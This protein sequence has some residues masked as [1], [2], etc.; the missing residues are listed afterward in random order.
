MTSAD[1]LLHPVRLRIIQA[2]LGDRALTTAELRSELPDVPP[3]S[4]YRHIARLAEA[5]VLSVASE[6]RVRG[7]VERTYVLRV[8]AATLN[9]DE[10]ERMSREDHRQA[11]MAFVAGL[12]GDFDRY[13]A[14]QQ[15][16][17]LRDGVSYR[18][19]GLWLT[20]GELAELARDLLRVIQPRLANPAR[21]G[22]RRRILASVLLPGED[23]AE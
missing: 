1:L 3:A 15:I 10:L 2:F 21:P 18:V 6:R 13:L 12:L 23:R 17:V 7:A 11:F 19:A 5:G 22:R 4:L 8:V 20:D 14:R 9:I 16:D